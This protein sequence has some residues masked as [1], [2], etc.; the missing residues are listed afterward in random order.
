MP[1]QCIWPSLWLTQNNGFGQVSNLQSE[2]RASFTI[3]TFPQRAETQNTSFKNSNK[4]RKQTFP[5]RNSGSVRR[6]KRCWR[7]TFKPLSLHTCMKNLPIRFLQTKTLSKGSLHWGQ[8]NGNLRFYM[9]VAME[10]RWSGGRV[11]IRQKPPSWNHLKRGR[12]LKK[13]ATTSI[14]SYLHFDQWCNSLSL[15]LNERK[16]HCSVNIT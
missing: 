12:G 14:L 1:L 15:L 5:L 6:A 3:Q 8:F 16:E 10:R 11:V 4:R 2:D 13:K 9:W 7:W